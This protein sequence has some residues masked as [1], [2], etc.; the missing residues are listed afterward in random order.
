MIKKSKME[1]KSGKDS[2]NIQIKEFNAGLS[3]K[4]VKDLCLDLITDKLDSYKEEASV[5]AKK[6]EEKLRN[7]FINQL[8]K[9]NI[10]LD[11]FKNP[12]MQLCYIEAQKGY[13]SYGDDISEEVLIELLKT[14]ISESNKNI[15]QIS[16]NEAV[17]VAPLL[18]K[19]HLDA[20]SLLFFVKEM[21]IMGVKTREELIEFIKKFFITFT[22]NNT[23]NKIDFEHLE[24]NKCITKIEI[25]KTDIFSIMKQKYNYYFLNEIP[26]DN[27][28]SAYPQLCKYIGTLK[29]FDVDFNNKI[30][31][32][33]VD[34]F[35]SY[36][37]LD[38]ISPDDR[39]I[40]S[41]MIKD[42]TMSDKDFEKV[43]LDNND[44]VASFFYT[45]HDSLM[46]S[47]NLTTI[48]KVLAMVNIKTQLNLP[49]DMSI[50]L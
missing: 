41:K 47:S 46:S 13:I 35:L 17:K 28:K 23:L 34:S 21:S 48:G 43:F 3:Y 18:M 24:Y 45:W 49:I 9:E 37:E 8:E 50:W 6:R 2:T 44:S 29:Y 7:D 14:R 32:K 38:I 31:F 40:F 30:K 4:D 26:Y 19:N 42:L 25:V 1:Q 33:N 11:E 20:L 15:L 10:K 16:L 36:N 22:K 27:F 39:K 5:E 12:S